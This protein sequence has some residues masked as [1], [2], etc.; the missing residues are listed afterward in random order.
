MQQPPDISLTDKAQAYLRQRSV[1]DLTLELKPLLSCCVPYSP[2][3]QITFGPPKRPSHFFTLQHQELTLHID[4][5]LYD[6]RR[7]TIDKHG[8]GIF[9]WLSVVNWRPLPP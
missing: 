7:L 2:P 1:H 4:Q 8:F 5:A 3:P 6:T 9:S